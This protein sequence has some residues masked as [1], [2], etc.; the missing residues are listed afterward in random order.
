MPR[1]Y[2][3]FNLFQVWFLSGPQNHQLFTIFLAYPFDSLPVGMQ[4]KSYKITQMSVIK[5]FIFFLL[6]LSLFIYNCG[7]IINGHRVAFVKMIAFSVDIRSFGRPSLCQV[8]I[9]AS[10]QIKFNESI[11][12]VCGISGCVTQEKHNFIGIFR[13]R[14]NKAKKIWM[15]MRKLSPLIL[16]RPFSIYF[17]AIHV[18]TWA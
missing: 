2:R 1:G 17:L 3:F 7:S 12:S 14:K 18:D 15:L 13:C 9:V 10:S 8:A 16:G 4:I 6:P 11:L 5:D